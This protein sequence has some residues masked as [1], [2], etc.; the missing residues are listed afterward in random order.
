MLH[1]RTTKTS[2]KK[3]AVQIV[4]YEKRRLIV[5][6]HIGSSGSKNELQS[7]KQE[8][9]SWIEKTTEQE[10]LFPKEPQVVQLKQFQYLGFRYGLLYETLNKIFKHFNFSLS[11]C[12]LFSPIR[13]S[14]A[15]NAI[16]ILSGVSFPFILY[17]SSYHLSLVFLYIF[18]YTMISL[19]GFLS[20]IELPLLMDIVN[21]NNNSYSGLI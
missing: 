5:V 1:I 14:P 4:K 19:I 9:K 10:T 17:Y 15:A 3:I 20:G 18:V 16:L 12:T 7:L 11:S 13:I 6:K 21:N 2:S 8:A